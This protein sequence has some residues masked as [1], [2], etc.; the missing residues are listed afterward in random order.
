[1]TRKMLLIAGAAGL[2][3]TAPA[4]AEKGG[5][6]GGGGGP[7]AERQHVQHAQ[8]AARPQRAERQQARQ[9]ERAQRFEQRQF[10]RAERPQRMER[11][12]RAQRIEQPRFERVQR[13]AAKAER[14][15]FARPE[16]I[17]RQSVRQQAKF[18]RQ[19]VRQQAKIE[20]K[21][22]QQAARID[23]RALKDEVRFERQMAKAAV[24]PLREAARTRALVGQR[25]AAAAL[26]P[27][28]AFYASRYVDTP[29][30]YY[31]YDND[32]GALYRID[33]DDNIVRSLIP[34][35]GGYSVGERWPAA[36]AS[37]YVPNAYQPFYY[38]RPD[39]YYRYDGNAIY[40]VDPTTQLISGIVALLTG[41]QLGVGQMLPASYGAYN[42]PLDYRANYYDTNDSWY[43]YGDGFIYQVDPYSRRIEQA[44]PLYSDA[45]YVG[46][47]WPTAYP[48]YNVPYAYRDTYYDT[49]QYQYR[50]AGNG[51]YQV[52]PKTQLITALVQL[53][54]GQQFNVGQPMP[55]GYGVYNVPLDYRDRWADSDNEYYRYANGYVY[56]IDADT[57]LIED[58]YPVHA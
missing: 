6:K 41:Q 18:E 22:F 30:Y 10:Q 56:Q 49:P 31:R 37:N 12:E 58:A 17:E 44:Y 23:R 45:Y 15:A 5:N 48:D 42:V 35:I 46:Q 11:I 32:Y 53:V 47:E 28:P 7:K 54:T 29:D 51:I 14:K 8:Q 3:I 52:D 16:R 9:V 1:M 36:Y 34:L 33:R 21:A 19:A 38:D 39:A 27:L 43:R 4:L 13:Q 26:A 25:V 57:G 55:A 24:R 2:A 20:R 40:Q 50:Y